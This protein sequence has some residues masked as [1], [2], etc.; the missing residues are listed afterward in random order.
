M[1]DRPDDLDFR[2]LKALLDWQVEMG[3]TEAIGDVPVNRYDAPEPP[4]KVRPPAAPV[5]VAPAVTPEAA[6]NPVAEA[7][8][9]AGAAA[10]LPALAAALGAFEH[11]EL[12]RGA[13][14]LVFADGDPAARVMFVGEAPGRD[15]DRIGKPFVGQAGQLLDRMLAAIGL[16]RT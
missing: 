10:T 13:R 9:A 1:L 5:L 12:K 11:C 3:A 4:K 16:D 8:A 15:E 6:G 7:R 14:Q 2:T